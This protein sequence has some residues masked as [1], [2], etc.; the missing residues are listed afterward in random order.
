MTIAF[1]IDGCQYANWSETIFC[2]LREGGVDAILV[3]ICYHEDFR[4]TV[5]NLIDWNGHFA[6]YPNL[7]M[8]GTTA[9]DVEAARASGRTAVFF[10]LQ[11]CSAIEDD[12]GLVEIL[13]RL[14]IRVMQ[15][16][17]NNQSL[18]G[19]G[20]YETVDTGITRMGRE[21]IAEM[22]RL[23]LVVDLSHSGERTCLEAIDISAR[24]V[25]ITHA[26]P[27]AWHN[28]ARNKS[29][30]VIKALAARGGM[31]G[32]SLYPHHLAGGSN[33]T[34]ESFTQMVAR[35]VD[36][37]GVDHIGIGSDLC[38]DQPDSVVAWM[39]NG[40]WSKGQTDIGLGKAAFPPQPAWFRDNR[41]FPT[42]RSGLSAQGFSASEVDRLMGGNWYRFFERSFG[43][44]PAASSG[45]QQ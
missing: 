10:A 13:H 8:P 39:R 4:E 26:N 32:L 40:R 38:Q 18:L 45:R 37:V 19:T 3:T 22:N 33:C 6:R 35:L 15:I 5:E 16:T 21:V 28:V 36:L 25:A 1:N 9:A 17:Y 7:I 23:G 31:L 34:L 29:D 12:I 2:Q 24:P 14:G 43:P 27:S 11:N 20:C 30:A 41:D 42:V 44:A